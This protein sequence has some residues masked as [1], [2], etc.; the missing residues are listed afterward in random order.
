MFFSEVIDSW[1]IEDVMSDED[2]EMVVA[3]RYRL[4]TD[5]ALADYEKTNLGGSLWAILKGRHTSIT[6]LLKK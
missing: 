4:A 3:F 1:L 6:V 5:S 2:G